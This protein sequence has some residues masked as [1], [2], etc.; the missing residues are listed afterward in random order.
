[1]K[2]LS[3]ILER[4][5]F[6]MTERFF[7]V[8]LLSC[9]SIGI[10]SANEAEAL[11]ELV[12][13]AY[14]FDGEYLS[15]IQ[16][17]KADQSVYDQALAVLLPQIDAS[18][19]YSENNYLQ[20][21]EEQQGGSGKIVGNFYDKKDRDFRE[22]KASLNLS[23]IVYD[24]EAFERLKQA[25]HFVK[26]AVVQM[27]SAGQALV[28]RVADAY[29]NTLAA[30][31]NLVLSEQQVNIS[32]EALKLAW[33]RHL[34]G[35]ISEVEVM[36]MEARILSLKASLDS[37][38]T[39]FRANVRVL[40]LS[41]GVRPEVLQSINLAGIS[42]LQLDT[43]DVEASLERSFKANPE[44]VLTKL[45]IDTAEFGLSINQKARFPKVNLAANID[46]MNEETMTYSSSTSDEQNYRTRD[47]S[48]A[49]TVSMPL[50]SGG[51]MTSRIRESE[52]RVGVAETD[53]VATKHRLESDVRY[54]VDTLNSLVGRIESLQKTAEYLDEVLTKQQL[55]FDRGVL[56]TQEIL[57]AQDRAFRAK[58]ELVL[59]LYD[60]YS[61]TVQL[62]ALEGR[63]APDLI[64]TS[65][66]LL[67]DRISLTSR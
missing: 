1:V 10:A 66:F 6:V 62:L 48:A 21:Q 64:D 50:Y 56:G 9:C 12:E 51:A 40:E 67:G 53:F 46:W 39:E 17:L 35:D 43:F 52:M 54:T 28:G 18:M 65:G 26:V 31:Q 37:A 24:A 30:Y 59:A 55:A 8:C 23:Q 42:S 58:N 47:S 5:G 16:S 61:A 63:L 2:H 44:L 25:D 33:A 14:R 3:L 41:T 60:Y 45:G 11:P 36:D 57:D 34:A 29:F 20:K 38:K 4:K 27:G 49:I 13:R 32:S 19:T 22:R 15:V 7:A